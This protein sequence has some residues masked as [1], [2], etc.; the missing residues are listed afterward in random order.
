MK[1]LT[2]AH[3]LE[4]KAFIT[5]FNLEQNSKFNSLYTGEQMLVLITGEGANN[6]SFSLNKLFNLGD[7]QIDRIINMGTCGALNK[8][9]KIG[10]PLVIAQV[11][12]EDSIESAATGQVGVTCV[13]AREKVNDELYRSKLKALA[14]ICDREAWFVVNFAKKH[15]KEFNCFKVISDFSTEVNLSTIKKNMETFGQNLLDLYL[16]ESTKF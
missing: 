14:D 3:F 8:Q 4:A 2:F 6:V 9:L 15:G 16:R 10:R 13:S 1:L 12:G 7:S 5:H 11:L